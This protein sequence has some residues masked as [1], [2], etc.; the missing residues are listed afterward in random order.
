MFY[1]YILFSKKMNRYYVGHTCDLANRIDQHNSGLSDYTSKTNDWE[2]KYSE[3]Y[4]SR[5]EAQQREFAIKRKKS[6]KYIEWLI[7]KN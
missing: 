5:Q 1:V 6:R 3:S 4:S 7:T 2:L